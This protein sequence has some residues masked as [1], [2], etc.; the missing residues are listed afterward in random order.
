MLLS[1]FPSTR[2]S[3]G[4]CPQILP[5][6][7]SC[8]DDGQA[9]A[10][11]ADQRSPHSQSNQSFRFL[12]RVVWGT[13]SPGNPLWFTIISNKFSFVNFTFVKWIR[14]RRKET[15]IIVRGKWQWSAQ[16]LFLNA[17][18]VSAWTYFPAMWWKAMRRLRG[19]SN[20]K[21]AIERWFFWTVANVKGILVSLSTNLGIL[22]PVLVA[23]F[24][25]CYAVVSVLHFWLCRLAKTI[26]TRRS[27]ASN[28]STNLS[29]FF[30]WLVNR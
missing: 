19:K 1:F 4:T 15:V 8:G 16:N 18:S 22:M 13:W 21:H 12:C 6:S 3:A 25:P 28:A 7:S 23:I 10:G 30:V 2:V 5:Q 9:F 11:R 24:L 20:A 14:Q 27:N 26:K 29:T 17:T